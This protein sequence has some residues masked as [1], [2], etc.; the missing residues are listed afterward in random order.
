MNKIFKF[1]KNDLKPKNKFNVINVGDVIQFK[2]GKGYKVK[3]VS[4][5][6]GKYSVSNI[7]LEPHGTW[8]PLS[9]PGDN[10]LEKEIW[11]NIRYFNYDMEQR[12]SSIQTVQQ[13]S[14]SQKSNFYHLSKE[15]AHKLA[16]QYK[17][18]KK[19]K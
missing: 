14:E 12:A 5:A 9:L 1:L 16:L 15:E 8:F 17:Q 4:K 11:D 18:N 7:Y 2:G 3:R 13:T 10:S 19:L 6:N